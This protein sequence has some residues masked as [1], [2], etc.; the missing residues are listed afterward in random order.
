MPW[1]RGQVEEGKAG[2]VRAARR[3]RRNKTR[4]KRRK[5]KR[6]GAFLGQ[7]F[8]E[9]G[10]KAGIQPPLPSPPQ[11]AAYQ[12]QLALDWFGAQLLQLLALAP[13]LGV[14]VAL[15]A[16]RH[17]SKLCHPPLCQP[18][19]TTPSTLT[20]TVPHNPSPSTG[21]RAWK[22]KRSEEGRGRGEKQGGEKRPR[23][24]EGEEGLKEAGGG[25]SKH[26]PH[27]LPPDPVPPT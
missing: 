8:V 5:K 18:P 22:R 26:N 27:P 12:L 23:K 17:G 7:H 16:L 15:P 9:G 24:E 19:A 10:G 14:A 2:S 21:R 4:R 3:R 20:F 25:R 13:G 11:G 1:G 6:E